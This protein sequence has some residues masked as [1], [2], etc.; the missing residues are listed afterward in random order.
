MN[1]GNQRQ[2]RII[3]EKQEESILYYISQNSRNPKRDRTI[4]LLSLKGGLRSIEISKLKW[5]HL[6]NSDGEFMD[7]IDLT[8]ETSKGNYG[9]RKIPLNSRL[10][11][12][13]IDYL[14]ELQK[15]KGRWMID[16]MNEYVIETQRTNRSE[17]TSPQMITNYFYHLYRSMGMIGYGSHSGR[18]T[19]IT[20]SSRK[21]SLVDGSLR[22]IQQMVGHRSLSTTQRY[23]EENKESKLKVVEL[24]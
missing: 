9:G 3:T 6:L 22:D 7:F 8:N 23:I 10:R 21:I 12:S 17:S 18:R 1:K 5:I 4:F 20:R 14:G 19:F 13:L 11:N 16:L 24:I 2:M 15:K